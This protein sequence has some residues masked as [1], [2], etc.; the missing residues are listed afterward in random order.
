MQR[1][2]NCI[3]LDTSYS[4]LQLADFWYGSS[5]SLAVL[6]Q[7]V[8]LNWGAARLS[9]DVAVVRYQPGPRQEKKN[10]R[11]PMALRTSPSSLHSSAHVER[12]FQQPPFL[13]GHAP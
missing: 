13:A 11:R 4:G 12:G 7:A 3:H 1:R 9:K 6:E 2:S 8:C 5:T 10:M